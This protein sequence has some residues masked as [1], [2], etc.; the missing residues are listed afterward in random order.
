MGAVSAVAL[1]CEYVRRERVGRSTLIGVMPDALLIPDFPHTI[2]RITVYYRIKFDVDGYFEG[3]VLPSIEWDD[4]EAESRQSLDPMPI[5]MIEKAL[6]TARARKIPFITMTGRVVL[7]DPLI[8]KKPG[9]ILAFLNVGSE[10]VICGALT[11]IK[12]D[13]SSASVPPSEQSQHAAEES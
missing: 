1:F 4:K 11:F 10:K 12:S 2:E 7:R 6:A 9:Q 13:R 5:E 3:P 8:I